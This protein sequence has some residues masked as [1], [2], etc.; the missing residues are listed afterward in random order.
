[1]IDFAMFEKQKAKG[2]PIQFDSVIGA[3]G[4]MTQ[5]AGPGFCQA[6]EKFEAWPKEEDYWKRKTD[7]VQS[8]GTSDRYGDTIEAIPMTQWWRDMNKPIP[9]AW[10]N[11]A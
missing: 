11:P 7:I 3:D 1:M 6:H 5:E 2:E 8:I 4:K 10:Q 9:S